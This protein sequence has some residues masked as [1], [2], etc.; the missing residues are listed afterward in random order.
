MLD[1]AN[2]NVIGEEIKKEME[3]SKSGIKDRDGECVKEKLGKPGY[4]AM[5]TSEMEQNVSANVTQNIGDT[6][7]GVSKESVIEKMGEDKSPVEKMEREESG[8]MLVES[9]VSTKGETVGES[10]QKQFGEPKSETED[11]L[12]ESVKESSMELIETMKEP[13]LDQNLDDHIPI[14][15]SQEEFKKSGIQ[16]R[17]KTESIEENM[18]GGE[19]E[20]MPV[21]FG[22]SIH[23]DIK[24]P[25]IETEDGD[26]KYV[27]EKAGKEEFDS[28][29]TV[30]E[31]FPQQLPKAIIEESKGLSASK[32]Q[33]TED[34]K[35][36]MTKRNPKEIEYFVDEG[37]GEERKR[38]HMEAK[39]DLTKET[40]QESEDVKEAMAKR[41]GEEIDYYLDEGEGEEPRRMHTEAKKDLTTERMQESEDITE[42]MVKRKEK[43]IE[44]FAIRLKV[45]NPEGCIW[46]QRRT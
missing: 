31:E 19:S 2:G 16:E 42:V 32:M 15:I 25:K 12:K 10:K 17:E 13:K 44:N 40:M 6:S 9:N 30:R 36:A 11:R 37:E 26:Q 1:D 46:K 45:K 33:E 21:I 20:K 3:E 14:N 5:E 24:K 7:Q 18:D 43:E 8:E 41:D 28:M 29:I 35:E 4:K 34:V 39:K 22:D 27:A 23:K 38:I